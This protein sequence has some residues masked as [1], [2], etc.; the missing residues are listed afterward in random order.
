MRNLYPLREEWRRLVEPY[1]TNEW[2]SCSSLKKA[3]TSPGSTQ[4]A[5]SYAARYGFIEEWIKRDTTRQYGGLAVYYRLK[6][7]RVNSDAA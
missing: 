5:L 3:A 6:Q 1:L 4:R 7:Q 2:Q